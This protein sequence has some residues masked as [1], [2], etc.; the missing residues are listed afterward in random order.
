M[1]GEPWAP[2]LAD[3]ARHVPTRTHDTLSPGSDAMLGTFN[4]NTTPDDATVQQMIDDTVASLEALVGDMPSVTA[5][6]PELATALRVYVEFSVAADIE[7]AYPNRDAD[8]QTATALANR[9][10]QQLTA[11]R[12]ALAGADLGQVAVEPQWAFPDPALT[13][14]ADQSP[15]SGADFMMGRFNWQEVQP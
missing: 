13:P 11:I 6:H 5:Q 10:Q 1:P 9:A 14:Y 8:I 12:A 2:G 15:G 4:G 3:V 7:L